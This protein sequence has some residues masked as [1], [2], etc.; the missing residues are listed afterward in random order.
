MVYYSK[1][2]VRN[3]FLTRT[4]IPSKVTN[5][6]DLLTRREENNG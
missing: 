4:Q 6:C 5:N 1:N 3:I 2:S